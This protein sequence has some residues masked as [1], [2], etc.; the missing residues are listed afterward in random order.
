[1][2]DASV[3]E[4]S[5]DVLSVEGTRLCLGGKPSPFRGLSFFN[6]LFNPAFNRDD[7]LP[8]SMGGQVLEITV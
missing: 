8:S 7:R 1:M 5:V 3:A 2:S 6:A 4:P